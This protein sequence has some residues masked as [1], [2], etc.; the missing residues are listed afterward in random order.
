MFNL[1]CNYERRVLR[2]LNISNTDVMDG[3]HK[4][5]EKK[6]R[7]VEKLFTENKNAKQRKKE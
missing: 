6:M 2:Y 7:T 1:Q 4:F 3:L 5:Q